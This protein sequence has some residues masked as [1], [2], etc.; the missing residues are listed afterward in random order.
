MPNRPMTAMMKSKP[1]ISSVIPKVRR[2]WPVTMSSPTVARIKPIRIDTSDLSGLPP[3]SPTKLEKA[4][5]FRRAEP[6]S[7]PR[8]DWS[9]ERDQHDRE[10]SADKGR[11]KCPGQRLTALSLP[12]HRVAV[13][14]RGD[15]PRL[16][17][18]VEKYRSDG[19]PEK[20]APVD[21]SQKN[22]GGCRRHRERHGKQNGHA[23]GPAEP[24]QHA[25][26][27]AEQDA[28]DRH[29]KIEWRDRDVKAHPK[30]F[31][32]HRSKPQPLFERPLGHR[33]EKP[34][35]ENQEG[36]DRD[37]ERDEDDHRP[38]VAAHPAHVK[39]HVERGR[40]VEADEM[41]QEDGGDGRPEHFENRGKL[42]AADEALAL[43]TTRGLY[44]NHAAHHDHDQGQPEWKES[45]SRPVRP[46]PEAEPNG[47]IGRASCRE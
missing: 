2:S 27:R 10:K 26:D 36:A 18:D 8:Q 45:T 19:P 34:F 30:I 25:D 44:E 32:S 38:R 28:D 35:L 24:R 29:P 15:R 43:T 41:H 42:L 14:S 3:P 7:D 47:K 39:T 13:E 46:P 4:K 16:A 20:R 37:A 5:D 1:F 12:R 22:D 40:D 6:E 31:D 17:G 23:V 11:G 33:H 21:G 9:E